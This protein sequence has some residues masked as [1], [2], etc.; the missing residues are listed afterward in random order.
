[1]P[2]YL[3][4]GAHYEKSGRLD[5]A[6]AVYQKAQTVAGEELDARLGLDI[7]MANAVERAGKPDQAEKI[8][9]DFIAKAE[10]RPEAAKAR[11]ALAEFLGRARRTADA[12]AVIGEVLAQDPRDLQAL[13]TK[14]KLAMAA[15]NAPEAIAAFRSALEVQPESGEVLTLLAAA[16]QAGGDTGEVQ[17]TLEQAV[18]ATPGDFTA[19]RNLVQLLLQQKNL[20]QALAQADDYLKVRPG[21]LDGLNLK[22]ELLAMDKQNDAAVEVLQEIRRRYPDNVAAALRLGSYHLNTKAYDKALAEYGA[23][24]QISGNAYEPVLG[25]VSVHMEMKKPDKAQALVKKIL[26]ENPKHPGAYQVLSAVH[27]YQNHADEGIK[28]LNQAIELKP[29]WMLPYANLGAYYEKQGQ[30]E[31]ALAVYRKALGVAPA[32][33]SMQLSVARVYENTN[34]HGKAIEQYETILKTAPDNLLAINNLASLLSMAPERADDLNRALELAK[35]LE[36]SEEPALRDTLAWLY[37]LTGD[38]GKAVPLQ[39]QAVEKSPQTPIFRYHLGMMY[40]KQG[41]TAKAKEHLGKALEGKADFVGIEEAR[42]T[43]KGLN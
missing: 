13:V 32:D 42:T 1:L 39:T 34:Q 41:D 19:R 28:A 27:F 37:Y 9:R 36:S 26:A 25:E 17:E 40:A 8:Y 3:S 6:L 30:A 33:I 23:A 5:D 22:A 14:G 16:Q 29:D 11:L 12:Q 15:K 38:L 21:S 31:S 20:A 18:R 43:L 7:A 10:T 2:P 4:L 35:R 24:R